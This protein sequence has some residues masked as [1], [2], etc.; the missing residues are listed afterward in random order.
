META[1]STRLPL[2]HR[3]GRKLDDEVD[4]RQGEKWQAFYITDIRYEE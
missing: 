1:A 4:I 2:H 3:R